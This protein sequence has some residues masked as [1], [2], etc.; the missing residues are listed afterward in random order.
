MKRLLLL[1]AALFMVAGVAYAQDCDCDWEAIPDDPAWEDGGYGWLGDAGE[2]WPNMNWELM[3]TLTITGEV[4]VGETVVLSHEGFWDLMHVATWDCEP[5][6]GWDAGM[7]AIWD[8]EDPADITIPSDLYGGSPAYGDTLEERHFGLWITAFWGDGDNIPFVLCPAAAAPEFSA[9]I[10]GPHN[11]DPGDSVVLTVVTDGID[12]PTYLWGDAT[13][14]STLDLGVVDAGDTGV[15]TC[16][17]NGT[18]DGDPIDPI[19]A[20]FTLW[21]GV[22]TPLAGGLGLGLLAGACAL[23]GAVSIRR[24]K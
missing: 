18:V 6:V 13:T 11:A 7:W 14:A 1:V 20:S 21:V 23:A 24:K 4:A 19:A 3:D 17:V 9:R 5:V 12:S 10:T 16:T 2:L 8:I 15:Y 22:A